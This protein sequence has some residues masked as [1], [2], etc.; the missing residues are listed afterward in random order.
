MPT[1]RLFLQ[2]A[3]TSAATAGAAQPVFE[4]ITLPLFDA[5]QPA[6]AMDDRLIDL[7][8]GRRYRLFR[9]IPKAEPPAR[10]RPVLWLTDGNAFF[11]RMPADLLARF[12][13]LMVVG[14]G[15]DTSLPFESDAR[16]LD[17]TPPPIRPDPRRP[18]RTLGGADTFLTRVEGPLREFVEGGQLIDPARRTLGGHSFGGLFTIYARGNGSSFTRYCAASPSF[19][20]V[21]ELEAR[22]QRPLTVFVGDH[23]RERG[24]VSEPENPTYRVPRPTEDFVSRAKAGGQ[25]VSLVIL[26]G[27]QHGQTLAGSLPEMMAIATF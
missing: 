4:E 20:L 21:P 12:P 14:I 3:L 24:E 18:D 13:Q 26:P 25:D 7:P 16:A 9:A 1:R 2:G 17:Y 10:G 5:E 22:G 15:Y 19:W 11:D 6:H 8:D 27:M 23:E